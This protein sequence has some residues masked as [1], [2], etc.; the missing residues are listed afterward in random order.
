M[1]NYLLT[2]VAAMMLCGVLTSCSHDTD[3]VGSA[4]EQNIRE[5]YEKAFVTR[6]GTPSPNQDWGFG[7]H[8][9]AA[10]TRAGE[11][12]PSVTEVGPTFNAKMA[13]MCDQLAGA[14]FSTSGLDF[15]QFETYKSWWG[16]GWN[17]K[18]YQINAKVVP[19][20]YSDDYLN[21][22]RD[23]ILGILPENGDNLSKASSTGYTITTMGGP[24]TLTPVYH[25]SSSADM[26]SYYYYPSGSKP[27]VEDIKKLPKYSIGF[28]ADPDECKAESGTTSFYRSTFSLVYVDEYGHASYNFPKGYDI[29]FIVTNYDLAHNSD[30]TV[31]DKV[32]QNQIVTK[33]MP[34]Y[35]EFYGD[36]DLNVA[37]HQ[38]GNDQWRL[39]NIWWTG[40]SEDP[41][42]PHVAVF[43]IGEKNYV[44]FEDWTD[45]DFNDIIF[46]V[47]GTEGGKEIPDVDK[48]E[49]I[50]VIAEDLSVGQETDFDFN[51][52]VFDVRRYTVTT[53]KHTQ[54]D[55]EII[56]RA[57][58]GTLPLYVDGHE[59]H[60]AFDVDVNVMVNTNAQARGLRG[61]DRGPVTFPVLE[62]HYSGSTIGEIANSIDLY[63]IKE[64]KEC[65]L[66]APVGDIA[67]K[68]G[69]NCDFIW[70]DER[71][72][73]DHK[74]SLVGEGESQSLFGNW[75]QG[76]LPASDWYHM[77]KQYIVEYKNALNM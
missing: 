12:A 46:E 4:V 53:G 41:K 35:P 67:S 75:V 5:T 10:R 3:F 71:E 15:S 74:Y 58:G 62:G 11:D 63:V 55:V 26:I 1:K 34:N 59:V 29:N 8:I 36:G 76:I 30:L 48:W 17:D 54:G 14:I 61:A 23:L 38:C 47:T 19:T 49:E 32:E 39:P 33:G 6:F 27:S 70:C 57:A 56:L 42:T 51:D 37:I 66:T 60:E 28:M 25:N 16:S 43:S 13:A 40:R 50:R 22:A 77:A 65:R 18:F 72:D 21:Q 52:I 31:F 45:F 7:S 9:A 20:C 69:V 68:I 44:G 73:I 24:V 2:G 64:G